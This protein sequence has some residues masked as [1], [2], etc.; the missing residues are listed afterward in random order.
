[1]A[2][3]TIELNEVGAAP[4][5]YRLSDLQQFSPQSISASFD[6]SGAAGSFL[7]CVSFL[8]PDGTLIARCVT[9][10]AV[11]A[12]DSAE[13]TWAPFLRSTGGGGGGSAPTVSG[14][15]VQQGAPTAVAN[16]TT[17]L[18]DAG[19]HL[20][21]PVLA[22]FFGGGGTFVAKGL[23]AVTCEI[24]LN[25]TPWTAGGGFVGSL[26]YSSYSTVDAKWV[27]F[28]ANSALVAFPQAIRVYLQSPP[29]TFAA[30][31]QFF[32]IVQN[33]DGA[34]ALNFSVQLATV[35]AYA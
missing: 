6:G 1:M 24:E 8:A 22:N 11:T 25:T 35:I 3:G 15:Q 28:P 4:L 33:L 9:D 14:E 20:S 32:F 16:N 34:L 2:L 13:V 30:G 29:L 12:G 31:D 7:P 5:T 18:L 17:R 21:G 23:Y 26:A 19:T 27:T 10:A